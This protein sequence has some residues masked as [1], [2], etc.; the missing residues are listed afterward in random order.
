MRALV[1]NAENSRQSKTASTGRKNL[2]F[3]IS[4]FR[5]R[6]LTGHQPRRSLDKN[7]LTSLNRVFSFSS[8]KMCVRTWYEA[9]KKSNRRLV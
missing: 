8:R 1:H 9:R 5:R 6:R 3:L 2:M 7:L 4:K